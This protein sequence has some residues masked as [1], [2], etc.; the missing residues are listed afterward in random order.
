MG[1]RRFLQTWLK[2]NHFLPLLDKPTQRLDWQF[3]QDLTTCPNKLKIEAKLYFYRSETS[4]PAQN[5]QLKI[6]FYKN[7]PTHPHTHPSVFVVRS[8]EEEEKMRRRPG[9]GGLQTAAAARV[10]F[11]VIFCCF[12]FTLCIEQLSFFV[13]RINIGCWVKM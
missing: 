9:I 12:D 4:D 13:C 7:T 3:G 6:N 11:V 8:Y 5:L 2:I 1:W 10:C